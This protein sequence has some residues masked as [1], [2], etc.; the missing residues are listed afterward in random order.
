MWFTPAEACDLLE[1]HDRLIVFI[2]DSLSRQLQQGL[3][4][5]LTGSYTQGGVPKFSFEDAKTCTCEDAY[6]FAC[7]ERTFASYTGPGELVCPKWR[8]GSFVGSAMRLNTV[9]YFKEH[10]N[11]VHGVMTV[12]GESFRGS[13]VVLGIGLQ[14]MLDFDLILRDVY[15]PVIAH[16]KS[17]GDVRVLCMALPAPDEAKKPEA[18]RKA[19]GRAAIEHFN[20][21]VRRFCSDRGAEMLELFAPTA[22]ATSY[23]GTHYGLRV[24]ALL[25][26]VFLNTIA[27]GAGWPR[28]AELY[29][30]DAYLF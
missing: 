17:R 1:A 3:H 15:G 16:A 18:F 11:E 24:N 14:D 30:E 8:K 2:G 26:Q 12:G 20:E 13:V 21:Q 28:T 10:V 4:T 9:E 5:V 25:A 29:P 27:Q 6:M 19:Q 23:D 22:N 7:R